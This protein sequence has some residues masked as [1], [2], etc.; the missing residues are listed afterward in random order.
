MLIDGDLL[1]LNFDG[2]P[3]VMGPGFGGG[4]RISEH[5]LEMLCWRNA[6]TESVPIEQI[7]II[8]PEYRTAAN[9]QHLRDRP[10]YRNLPIRVFRENGGR[11]VLIDGRHRIMLAKEDGDGELEAEIYV[12]KRKGTR[13]DI[14]WRPAESLIA[15]FTP[16]AVDAPLPL[17]GRK[18]WLVR[19]RP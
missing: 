16:G 19:Q 13:N 8:G 15:F 11:T 1:N 2:T 7:E 10:H 6:G 12:P 9:L 4:V 18:V 3:S 14:E 17:G 5:V